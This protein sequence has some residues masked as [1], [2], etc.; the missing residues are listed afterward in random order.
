MRYL[1]S[2]TMYRLSQIRSMP[3]TS[4]ALTMT[5]LA[6]IMIVLAL[7][8]LVVPPAY[9]ANSLSQKREASTPGGSDIDRSA[10]LLFSSARFQKIARSDYAKALLAFT[11]DKGLER[12]HIIDSTLWEAELSQFAWMLFFDAA[13]RIPVGRVDDPSLIGYYNPYS[14]VFLVTA[15]APEEG[16]YKIVDAELLIGDWV[17]KDDIEIGLIPLWLRGEKYRPASVGLS[18][19]RSI[20][21]LEKTFSSAT[22]ANWRKKIEILGD[23]KALQ[24]LNYLPAGLMMNNHIINILDFSDPAPE[25]RQVKACRDQ[26]SS[27]IDLASKGSIEKIFSTVKDT[28]EIVKDAL[29]D[30][31]PEW[32]STLKVAAGLT[33]PDS[34]LVLLSSIEP[35]DGS[36]SLYFKHSKGRTDLLHIDLID[37]QSIYDYVTVQ[38][39][40]QERG[41][42]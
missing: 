6:K 14:D 35:S 31:P 42:P 8:T 13:I 26:T 24:E 4:F 22:I 34:C 32:F 11:K 30:I 36:I 28:P 38:N 40:K 9:A 25:D 20:L 37:Y 23:D 18:T 16:L 5:C 29:R 39:I 7:I 3:Q 19:A 17:R 2:N 33:S 12:L 41:G 27:I 15:W 1:I 10:P 21:A